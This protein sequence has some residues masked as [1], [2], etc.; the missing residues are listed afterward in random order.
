[1]CIVKLLYDRGY[2]VQCYARE[3][4]RKYA[5]DETSLIRIRE[6]WVLDALHDSKLLH[7]ISGGEEADDRFIMEKVFQRNCLYL[8]N[9]RLEKH[10]TKDVDGSRLYDFI[11]YRQ[12]QF[13]VTPPRRRVYVHDDTEACGNRLPW[14]MPELAFFEDILVS[15]RKFAPLHVLR[16]LDDAEDAKIISDDASDQDSV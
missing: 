1:M 10:F 7:Y 16:A 2:A 15:M 13:S 9:D 4:W 11:S 3:G 12:N 5:D 6:R 14:H 8:S